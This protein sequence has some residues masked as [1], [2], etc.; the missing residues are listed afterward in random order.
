[1]LIHHHVISQVE[2]KLK[3]GNKRVS[4]ANRKIKIRIRNHNSG[5]VKSNPKITIIA[6]AT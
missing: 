6:K 4:L 1:M 5:K 2:N 3:A